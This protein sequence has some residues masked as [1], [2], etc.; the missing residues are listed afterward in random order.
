[1]KKKC[2][3]TIKRFY[4]FCIERFGSRITFFTLALYYYF[5]FCFEQKTNFKNT[6]ETTLYIFRDFTIVWSERKSWYYYSF[7]FNILFSRTVRYFEREKLLVLITRL[8]TPIWLPIY[9]S[10]LS[11]L[12]NFR[13]RTLRKY[14]SST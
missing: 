9:L 2:T 4:I 1:M 12:F 10:D 3:L 13:S 11:V 8:C 5:G 6:R 7:K 14:L